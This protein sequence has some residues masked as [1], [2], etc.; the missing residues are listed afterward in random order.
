MD[1]A[2][3]FITIQKGEIYKSVIG[4]IEKALIEKA[5]EYTSGN[6]ITAARL[7]GINRNTIRSKIKKLNIDVNRFK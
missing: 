2:N 3:S 5:L 6:Q 7:L 4:D 1:I